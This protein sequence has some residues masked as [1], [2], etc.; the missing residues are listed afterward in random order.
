MEQTQVRESV[1]PQEFLDSLKAS[2]LLSAEEMDRA[3]SAASDSTPDGLSFA[4]ALVTAGVLTA[5]QMEAVCNGAYAD[6]R[7]GN[8]DVL[9]RLGA[10]GMGTVFKGPRPACPFCQGSH[11]QGRAWLASR[12]RVRTTKHGRIA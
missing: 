4:R 3:A 7:I 6:L 5:Y 9:D 8:Y 10:G 12:P 2:G 1:S 11:F